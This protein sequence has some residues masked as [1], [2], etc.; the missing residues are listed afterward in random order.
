MLRIDDIF[1]KRAATLCSKLTL[2]VLHIFTELS[3]LKLN[4][5]S[6]RGTFLWL[7]IYMRWKFL[8]FVM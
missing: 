7:N 2:Q 3:N 4:L 5:I 8:K 1:R 6:F